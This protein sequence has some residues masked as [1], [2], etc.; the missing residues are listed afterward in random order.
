[1]ALANGSTV[2]PYGATPLSLGAVWTVLC[3][4]AIMSWASS[5]GVRLGVDT[6][7]SVLRQAQGVQI[8]GLVALAVNIGAGIQLA[9]H[10]KTQLESV[11]VFADAVIGT[12]AVA[13]ARSFRS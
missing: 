8:V 5:Y 7:R 12:M 2:L 3:A 9:L 1:M 11:I 4:A 6:E 13:V 10:D